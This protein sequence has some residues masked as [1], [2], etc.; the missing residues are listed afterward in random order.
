VNIQDATSCS[1]EKMKF[2]V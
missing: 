2:K 1:H